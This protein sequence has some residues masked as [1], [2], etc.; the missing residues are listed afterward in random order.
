MCRYRQLLDDLLLPGDRHLLDCDTKY[1]SGDGLGFD[2]VH[3]VYAS[4]HDLA[5]TAIRGY[6]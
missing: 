1:D 2:L 3:A 6:L 4:A 5:A